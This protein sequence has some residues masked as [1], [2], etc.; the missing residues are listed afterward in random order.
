M[1]DRLKTILDGIGEVEFAAVAAGALGAERATLVGST[2]FV[3]LSTPHFDRKTIGIVRASGQARAGDRATARPWSTV[4]KISDLSLAPHDGSFTHV[5]DE[6]TVYEQRLFAGDGLRF[7]PARCYAISRPTPSIRVLW[8]ED[9]ID[10]KGTPFDV[11]ALK[12]IMRHLGEWNGH[13]AVR[14]TTVTIPM[15][16]DG[17]A[18]RWNSTGFRE[19]LKEFPAFADAPGWRVAFGDLPSSI[20]PELYGLL[21]QLVAQTATLP[22]AI[23]FGDL[24]AG[25]VFLKGDETVAVDWASLTV[26]PLGVDGGCLPGSSLTWAGG[27][28]IAA[29]ELELF[30]AYLAGLH[31]AGWTGNRDDVRRAFLCL[32]GIYQ[33]TCGLMPVYCGKLHPYPREYLQARFKTSLETIPEV[34]AGVIQR[35]PATIAELR[36]LVA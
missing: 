25:N 33:F 7:R 16:R 23:A 8:L 32:F 29:A 27:A 6:A 17:F 3:E 12:T 24:A 36:R 2:E 9:L 15:R 35:F 21:D 30:E 26:D 10:A 14:G 31:E 28:T 20:V 13:H 11:P 34:V 18:T 5:E 22:H 1:D 4:A 19:Q